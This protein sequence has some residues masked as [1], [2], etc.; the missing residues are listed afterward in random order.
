MIAFDKNALI[1]DLAETYNIYDYKSLPVNMVA[2]FSVGLREES[3][4]KMKMSGA[5]VTANTFILA[6]IADR[7]GNIIWS[8]SEDGRKGV[9]RPVQLLETIT[10]K[11]MIKEESDIVLFDSPED[12]E[13]ARKKLAERR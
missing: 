1:C 8:L 12:Y 9:N 5:K 11:A 2:T 3:R 7:L 6:I 10:G 13:S 4:I